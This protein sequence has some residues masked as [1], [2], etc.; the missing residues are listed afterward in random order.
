MDLSDADCEEA[1]QQF[2]EITHTDEACAHF[3]LQD[4]NWK[5]QASVFSFGT[6]PSGSPCFGPIFSRHSPFWYGLRRTN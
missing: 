5:L 3:F 4:F 1:L 6:K 2:V